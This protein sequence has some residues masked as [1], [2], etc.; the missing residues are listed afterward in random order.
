ML[1]NNKFRRFEMSNGSQMNQKKDGKKGPGGSQK[2]E[3]DFDWS[4]IMMRQKADIHR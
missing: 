1:F 2:P 4:K 3:G